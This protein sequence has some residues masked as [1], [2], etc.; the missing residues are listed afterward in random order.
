MI[1]R[2]LH[3]YNESNFWAQL[4]PILGKG[5]IGIESDTNLSKIGDGATAWNELK[6]CGSRD[7]D[8]KYFFASLAHVPRESSHN[9]LRGKMAYVY[10]GVFE[11]RTDRAFMYLN[12]K[13]TKRNGVE[14]NE[15]TK[16][17]LVPISYFADVRDQVENELE[18]GE[19]A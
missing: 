17:E 19:D 2:I 4:N 3:R 6:Y 18:G 15:E 1:A 8:Q 11:K 13:V 10:T 7:E 12:K 5:E 14:V 16:C 9:N